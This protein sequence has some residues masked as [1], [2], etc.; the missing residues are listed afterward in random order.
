MK[1]HFKWVPAPGD[2]NCACIT[3]GKLH[4]PE[5]CTGQVS[6]SGGVGS[7]YEITTEPTEEDLVVDYEWGAVAYKILMPTSEFRP[8]KMKQGSSPTQP[9]WMW[10]QDNSTDILPNLCPADFPFA[11]S[12]AGNE[13]FCYNHLCAGFDPSLADPCTHSEGNPCDSFCSHDSNA[14]IGCGAVCGGHAALLR[15]VRHFD[16]AQECMDAIAS[17]TR[18]MKTYIKYNDLESSSG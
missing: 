17:E 7:W 15:S 18:C 10:L 1:T 5:R 4:S 9:S 6:F 13:H 8:Y 11:S 12:I 3:A 16:T 2:G 14:V